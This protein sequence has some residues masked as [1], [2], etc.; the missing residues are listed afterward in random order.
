M[1]LCGA[2]TLAAAVSAR[3]D[4]LAGQRA[5]WA[6][7][8]GQRPEAADVDG[9]VAVDNRGGADCDEYRDRPD[10]LVRPDKQRRAG[11]AHQHDHPGGAACTGSLDG[12][13]YRGPGAGVVPPA[14]VGFASGAPD[15]D[16]TVHS[17]PLRLTP[18]PFVWPGTES[19][20]NG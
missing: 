6:V 7:H 3:A 2:D 15:G 19:P 16:T 14:G 18:C 11:A 20:E 8:V 10:D 4:P 12:P 9:G 17:P 13:Q 1:H 5:D